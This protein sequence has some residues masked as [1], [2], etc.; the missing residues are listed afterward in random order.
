MHRHTHT[1]THTQTNTH[2]HT[3]T[4]HS[5]IDSLAIALDLEATAMRLFGDSIYSNLIGLGIACQHGEFPE[6]DS[7]LEFGCCSYA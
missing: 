2:T 3:H 5:Q 7:R 6:L 1:H 4:C